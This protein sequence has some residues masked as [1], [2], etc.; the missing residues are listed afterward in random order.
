MPKP[1]STD[2]L[3]PAGPDYIA[4][5]DR[6]ERL[7]ERRDGALS[8]GIVPSPTGAWRA[9]PTCRHV[10]WRTAPGSPVYECACPPAPWAMGCHTERW[11]FQDWPPGR[12]QE[13]AQATQ[14]RIAAAVAE[15]VG[16]FG[17]RR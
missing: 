12:P 3:D 9:C 14:D 1:T 17:P 8:Y 15:S 6:P 7:P 5:Q 4:P 13:D 2:L 16:R 11:Y 10:A